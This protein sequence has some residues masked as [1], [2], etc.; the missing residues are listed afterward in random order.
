MLILF[1][2][3]QKKTFLHFRYD[4]SNCLFEAAYEKILEECQCTP[5]FHWGGQ[6]D[7]CRG[8]SLK[9]MNHILGK[10]GQYNHVG[11]KPCLASC[12]D[13]KNSVSITNY[14]YFFF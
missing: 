13:Q 8:N 4:I 5:Y 12:E 9:C 10:L 1:L 7:F 2:I 6:Y 11:G 3:V 14:K